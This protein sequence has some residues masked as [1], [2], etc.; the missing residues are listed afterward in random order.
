M[1]EVFQFTLPFNFTFFD[2]T[3]NTLYIDGGF[4]TFTYERVDLGNGQFIEN[5][6][7]YEM[8]VY[9][10]EIYGGDASPISYTTEG[11][12]GNRILKVQWKNCA[13]E[14]DENGTDYANFQLW[15]YENDGKLEYH[16]GPISVS[17]S[18]SYGYPA[19]GPTVSILNGDGTQ[20][21]ILT[22]SPSNPTVN[23]PGTATDIF[24]TD[25]PSEETVY[26]FTRSAATGTLSATEDAGIK[27]FPNPFKDK[28]TV[29]NE[30]SLAISEIKLTGMDGKVVLSASGNSSINTEHILPGVYFLEIHTPAGVARRKLIK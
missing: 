27:V 11:T 21:I 5:L 3:F 8:Y 7:G 18:D 17:G 30:G 20:G 29:S 10:S 13:F 22:G 1:D 9:D 19:E 6:A 4:A 15:L 23:S 2:Q 25:S 26:V 16:Y 28:L 12:A 24:M 14:P